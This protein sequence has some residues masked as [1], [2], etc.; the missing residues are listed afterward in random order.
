M[1]AEID[2]PLY[3]DTLGRLTQ[4]IEHVPGALIDT[5]CGSGHMLSRFHERYDPD[6]GLLGVDISDR[7]VAIA[8]ANV[9]TA[10]EIRVG[11]M[12]GLG[13]VET[14]SLAAVLSFFAVHHLGPEEAAAAFG[15]WARVLRP[16]GGQL[17]VAAWEGTGTIDYGDA[18]EIVA[19]R[20][21]KEQVAGWAEAAGLTVDR[22]VVEAVEGMPMD[23][24]YL[25]ATR[26]AAGVA[27][28]G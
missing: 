17:V 6:R 23:A 10:A 7:M 18:S 16:G 14:G 4:R 22:C 13:W 5:S 9:G 19:L 28:L 2:L 11:D 8:R 27:R 3:A 26:A 12:R 21:T 20:Y 25:E 24:V 15:E 1:D